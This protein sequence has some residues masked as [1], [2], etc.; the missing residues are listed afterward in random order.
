MQHSFKDNKYVQRKEA[1]NFSVLWTLL[2]YLAFFERLKARTAGLQRE[3]S[4]TP[5]CYS[6]I[7]LFTVQKSLWQGFP[8]DLEQNMPITVSL[9]V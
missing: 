4:Q 2:V 1:G 7:K 5:V 3:K 6:K 8:F 9:P